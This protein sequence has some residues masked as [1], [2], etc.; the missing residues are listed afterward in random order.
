M[1]DLSRTAKPQMWDVEKLREYENN[2]RIHPKFQ[3]EII[4]NSIKE[5]GFINP[6]IVTEDGE[7]VA[8]HGRFEA[9]QQMGLEKVPVLIV[10]YLTPDQINA[11]R[12]ADN[13]IGQLGRW[14]EDLL[15]IEIND[16]ANTD[17]D[18]DLLGFK[19]GD[20]DKLINTLDEF[21]EFESVEQA[22]DDEAGFSE[23]N[24]DKVIE[25]EDG[26][27]PDQDE[28]QFDPLSE[29]RTNTVQSK[30]GELYWLGD[31]LLYCG[32]SLEEKTWQT[33]MGAE[34]ADLCFTD[35]PYG[36]GYCGGGGWENGKRA[37][38]ERSRDEIDNDELVG[39][40]LYNFLMKSL[41]LMKDK[42]KAGGAI[43]VCC[44]DS[45]IG[46]P[47]SQAMK[48]LDLWRDRG[49]ELIWVKN[50]M[51]FG[52]TDYQYQHERI[53][54]GWKEGSAHYFTSD[55]TKRTVLFFKRPNKSKAHPTMKPVD[56][57][58]DLIMNSTRRNGVVI[59]GFGGSGT[60]LI[61]CATIGRKARLVELSP[62][63]CD[64]IR[65]RWGTFAT[66]HGLEVGDGIV[67]EN[68]AL[69]DQFDSKYKPVSDVQAT[70]ESSAKEVEEKFF[71]KN[72]N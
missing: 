25:L 49:G 10:D 34:K 62:V 13:Q 21:E 56:L 40:D 51:Q 3:I 70:Q 1:F 36:I 71:S 66:K 43:Y 19:T 18:L 68:G 59:D 38:G 64:V 15:R 61:A 31:H 63:Y 47:F 37:G 48:D 67:E 17:F 11:Y 55:R 72:S 41:G 20:L 33:L 14:D 35:P 42:L 24:P 22:A 16:L 65:K 30:S 5:F 45:G 23:T 46:F 4:K 50:H 39:A 57:V 28:K 12:I 8:G 26:Q 27:I 29:P 69:T 32:S 52:R 53:L 44:A 58:Q 6:I 7:I 60:T 2:T 54:Y 9:I